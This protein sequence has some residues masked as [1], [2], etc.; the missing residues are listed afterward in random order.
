MS[1]PLICRMTHNIIMQLEPHKAD[2]VRAL[3]LSKKALSETLIGSARAADPAVH[4]ISAQAAALRNPERRSRV[5]RGSYPFVGA[6]TCE[7]AN[8]RQRAAERE[9]YSRYG[10]SESIICESRFS[11]LT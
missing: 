3:F 2:S 10:K 8:W 4:L 9:R 11:I 6:K 7:R 5:H 1:I